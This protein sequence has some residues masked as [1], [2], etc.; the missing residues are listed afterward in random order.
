M[1]Q[2]DRDVN[3]LRTAKINSFVV[4]LFEYEADFNIEI[5]TDEYLWLHPAMNGEY[6]WYGFS[7]EAAVAMWWQICRDVRTDEKV[8]ALHDMLTSSGSA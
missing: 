5:E 2:V 1:K 4:T 6:S 7:R 8:L 3:V